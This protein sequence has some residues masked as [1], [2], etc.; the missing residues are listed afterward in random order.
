MHDLSK[1]GLMQVH[2]LSRMDGGNISS[3][4]SVLHVVRYIVSV[5][6]FGMGAG[7]LEVASVLYENM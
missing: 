4:S 5:Q 7:G 2:F 1:H 3:H 6:G